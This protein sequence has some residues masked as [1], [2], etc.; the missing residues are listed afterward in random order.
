MREADRGIVQG[1]RTHRTVQVIVQRNLQP[2]HP[3]R[4]KR[5]GTSHDQP[6]EQTRL[7][8]SCFGAIR[9]HTV[10]ALN[11]HDRPG[12][13]GGIR[14]V[15]ASRNEDKAG[16]DRGGGYLALV[17]CSTGPTR[18]RG[19]TT[20]SC[21][22]PLVYSCLAPSYELIA[23]NMLFAHSAHFALNPD[24][25]SSTRSRYSYLNKANP[26]PNGMPQP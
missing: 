21:L 19:A 16:L 11:A 7:A 12:R 14:V 2:R 9:V 22:P 8:S 23:R 25:R 1:Y 17:L 10:F 24:S 6:N 26:I 13:R 3:S 18:R 20:L 4:V 15:R 5:C